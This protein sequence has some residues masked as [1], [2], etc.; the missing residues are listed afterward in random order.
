MKRPDGHPRC[1][2][3]AAAL[4]AAVVLVTAGAA[5]ALAQSKKAKV[6][7]VIPDL[8]I[9]NLTWKPRDA[10]SATVT[11]DIAW[12][13]SW[14]SERNH[15][16]AWVFFKARVAGAKEWQHVRLV[17]DKVLD[18]AGFTQ[19]EGTRLE[20]LVPGGDDGFVGMFLRRAEPAEMGRIE[21]RGVTAVCALPEGGIP[22]DAALDVQAHGIE[23]VY[24]PEGPFRLGSGGLELNGFYEY[25]DG[26]N[27]LQPYTVTSAGPIPTGRQAGRLWAWRAAQPED[28]GELPAAFPNGFP[29]FYC[30][31]YRLTMPQYAA[32]LNTLPPE[33]AAERYHA[34][35][36]VRSGEPPNCTYASPGDQYRTGAVCLGL[37]WADGASYAAWAGIRPL[38]E[39]EL[40]KAIRGPRDPIPNELGGS[41]WGVFGFSDGT[42]PWA[43]PTGSHSAERAVT[44]GH[45]A[46]RR[47]AGTHGRGTT[48]LPADW[49]QADAVGAGMRCTWWGFTQRPGLPRTTMADPPG[50]SP[51]TKAGWMDLPRTRASDRYYAAHVD[52]D[53]Q[54]WHCWRGV[55][56]APPEAAK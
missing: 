28:G 8:R 32:F 10:A 18:P 15:D 31:R 19:A 52:P 36:A 51:K 24:V 3:C 7:A 21:A 53:R 14:R 54:P 41:Y 30:M 35:L 25:T 4:M 40:E 44:V 55:R 37:S 16:A 39:L 29:A 13:W 43:A 48:T 11:F 47:F 45:A 1:L 49:P 23:M 2:P 22:K 12:D 26:V 27:N 9:E 46:G 6:D 56:T 38:T 17:A 33:Q 5:P 50:Y 34:R 42:F 20:V